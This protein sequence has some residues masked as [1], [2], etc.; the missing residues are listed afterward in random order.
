M[1]LFTD[2]ATAAI[3]LAILAV[4]LHF[5]RLSAP[6]AGWPMQWG[7][8]GRPTWRARRDVAVFFHP[9]FAALMMGGF[10]AIRVPEEAAAMWGGVRLFQA[11]TLLLAAW[12]HLRY[13]ARNLSPT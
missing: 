6:D 1:T 12:L 11:A 5:R 4:A 3:W 8:D 10:A 13:A 2:I 7:F 9:V